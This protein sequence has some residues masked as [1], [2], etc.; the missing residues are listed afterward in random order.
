MMLRSVARAWPTLLAA[1]AVM[2]GAAPSAAAQD[3]KRAPDLYQDALQSI[4]EGRK[5]DASSTLM[6]VIENEPHNAGAYLEVALIQC[7]LG[8]SREAERLFAIIETRFEP[9]REILELISDAR[10]TGCN[11]WQAISAWS[12]SFGRGIDQNVNQGATNPNYIVRR[13]GEDVELPLLSDF[14]PKHDQYTTLSA[15]YMREVTPNGSIGFL[16]YQGRRNDSLRQYDSASLYAGVESPYRWGRWTLRTT[17]MLGQVYLG[18][19]AY[20]RQLQLQARVGPPL[21]LPGALQ[22]NLMGSVTRTEHLELDNFDSTTYELRGQFSYRNGDLSSSVSLGALNDVSSD[23]RPGGTRQGKALN[24][25]LRH[26]VG[27]KMSGELAYSHQDWDS[28]LPYLPGLIG[29]VR[30][31][32]TD[33][34]R[35]LLS[36]P[37]SKRQRVQLEARVVRNRENISIFQYNNKLLQLTW[38]WQGP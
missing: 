13:N 24:V 30:D 31:Q 9:K 27:Q 38:L 10:D 23:L 32:R 1:L 37:L 28:S 35:G 3:S 26:P 5:T 14:Y 29:E 19:H 20:Q 22:F 12:A 11:R 15:E 8:R 17:G 36:Y 7:A 18:G 16:Q 21:P 34:L 6:R 33:V 2:A 25:L 4:A